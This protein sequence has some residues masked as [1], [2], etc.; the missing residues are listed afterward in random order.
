MQIFEKT[1][2][3]IKPYENNPRNNDNAVSA[4]VASICE[5]GFKVPIVIDSDGVI[6]CGHTRY[7]AAQE[8]G[9]KTVPCVIADDLTPEQVKAFRL[10]DNKVGELATWDF[11]KLELE[12]AELETVELE[13]FG[14]DDDILTKEKTETTN[15]NPDEEHEQKTL[16]EKFIIPPFSVF[17]TRQGYW[18]QRTSYWEKTIGISST[19]GRGENLI[20]A[21]DK[22]ENMK[23]GFKGIAPQT[24]EFDA[25]LAEVC[26]K[27][28]CPKKGKIIDPFAGGS[29]RGIIAQ[30]LGFDY[31][32]FDIRH[33]QIEQNEMQAR[34][35]GVA[36][37]W[38]CESSLNADGFIE[39][40]TA[41]MIFSCPP[42]FDL[43]KYSDDP[44]DLSNMDWETFK[45]TYA[46]I[47]KIFCKKIKPNRFAVFVVGDIRD[48]KGF[49]RNFV[50][51]TKSAFLQNGFELYNDIVL[52][53]QA[54]TAAMRAEKTFSARRKLIKVHE[55]VLCFFKG[56]PSKIKEDFR[57]TDI[58]Q[59]D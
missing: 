8:I 56:N 19:Q 58:V 6:V 10:A 20:G 45:L 24:S 1:L 4:V 54:G 18:V 17:D 50:D 32:G 22:P 36:P 34:Q 29:V 16:A 40:G 46:E 35:I 49:Y 2:S 21:P 27:F 55:N 33:E 47:I 26:Y 43:E 11:E 13:K 51:Y 39:D 15:E 3:E 14:F 5:F 48:K 12:T 44:N 23:T 31:L 52:L 37:R 30:M 42:Y 25:T 59:N 7:K 53:Q 38:I 28:F 9:L 41:D 57:I